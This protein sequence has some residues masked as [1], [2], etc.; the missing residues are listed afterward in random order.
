[1][2]KRFVGTKS[3][4]KQNKSGV[5]LVTIL[6]ILAVAF[7][8]IGAAL[9][10]TANTR[11][12]LYS[13]AEGGQARITCTAAAQLFQTALEEQQI[14]DSDFKSMCDS[15]TVI[16]F[17]DPSTR[18]IPGMGGAES[19]SPNNY[20][21][22]KFGKSGSLYTVRITTKIG[23]EVENILLTY[24][25]S[26]PTVQQSPFAFQVELGEGGRLDNVKIGS[27]VAGSA[28]VNAEDNVIVTRGDGSAPIGSCDFFSTFVTTTHMRSASGTNYYG[29][30]VYAGD[31]AGI[32]AGTGG[33]LG[34]TG[35]GATL[36]VNSST[37]GAGTAFF[38]DCDTPISGA[39]STNQM[40]TGA[41][42]SQVI[43]TDVGAATFTNGFTGFGSNA[44]Y[45][46]HY[47]SSSG[48]I[49]EQAGQVTITGDGVTNMASGAS[50]AASASTGKDLAYYI[51]NLEQY[52]DPNYVDPVT[53][54]SRPSSFAEFAAA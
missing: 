14:R 46:V 13:F 35:S 40:F 6:F 29:D 8:L 28:R 37:G 27:N 10:M 16:Y 18:P 22:A 24:Q 53:S 9:M 50:F 17:T 32:I 19:T 38:I 54:T 20:T 11:K 23:D 39:G 36:R 21:K 25:G 33:D 51:G 26:I 2:L 12:R 44:I 31:D 47:D 3:G 30:I 48:A 52:K 49:S 4:K 45:Q 1:M 5:I 15:G 7:I 41:N 34:G 43:F 42:G